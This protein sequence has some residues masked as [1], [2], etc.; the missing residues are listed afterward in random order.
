MRLDRDYE[1][2]PIFITEN[3][4]AYQDRVVEG[5]VEDEQRRQYIESHLIALPKP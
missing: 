3:G 1:L 4:A 2:P 5:R